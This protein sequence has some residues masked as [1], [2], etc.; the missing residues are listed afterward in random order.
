MKGSSGSSWGEIEH[1]DSLLRAGEKAKEAGASAVAVVTRFPDQIDMAQIEEYRK[2][3]GVDSVSGAEAIISHLLVR[4]LSIPCA[5]APA[6]STLPLVRDIDPRVAAEELGYRDN[7]CHVERCRVCA[8]F[9]PQGCGSRDPCG[10]VRP[11]CAAAREGAGVR[12]VAR[13]ER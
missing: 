1:P 10:R 7:G 8:G 3:R 11:G 13:R 4:H 12:A 6:M 9:R 2:G 5:H